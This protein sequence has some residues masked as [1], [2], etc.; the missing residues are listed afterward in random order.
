MTFLATRFQDHYLSSS[1]LANYYKFVKKDTIFCATNDAGLASDISQYGYDS[2]LSSSSD[3]WYDPAV[4]VTGSN[5]LINVDL[6]SVGD[7]MTVDCIC[8]LSESSREKVIFQFIPQS[9]SGSGGGWGLGW[10]YPW[11]YGYSVVDGAPLFSAILDGD[12]VE[13]EYNDILV[14]R[15]DL[16]SDTPAT[17]FTC[18]IHWSMRVNP[19]ASSSVVYD[20]TSTQNQII[21][22]IMLV[23]QSTGYIS[24]SSNMTTWPYTTNAGNFIYASQH[25][26]IEAIRVSNAYHPQREHYYDYISGAIADT[27][28]SGE[29]GYD[30]DRPLIPSS[31][32]NAGEYFGPVP[33]ATMQHVKHSYRKLISP[34][35]FFALEPPRF[36]WANFTSTNNEL[37]F[38]IPQSDFGTGTAWQSHRGWNQRVKLPLYAPVNAVKMQIFANIIS[39]TLNFRFGTRTGMPFQKEQLLGEKAI[40]YT[41]GTLTGSGMVHGVVPIARNYDNTTL[42]IA[43]SGTSP[44]TTF[45]ITGFNALPVELSSSAGILQGGLGLAGG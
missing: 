39:G 44:T 21:H 34:W 22:E 5:S 41:T 6:S 23:N 30:R 20:S 4:Y 33:A 3:T 27:V 36:D 26:T 13:F 45:E 9:I 8:I 12:Q 11:G 37:V 17:A 18:S 7:G 28:N 14:R 38:Q 10:G 31:L 40:Y 16:P 19:V 43:V 29:G 2:V 24:Q 42:Y 25:P 35:N 32:A 1:F 15:L